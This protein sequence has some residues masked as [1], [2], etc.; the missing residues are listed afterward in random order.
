MEGVN[1]EVLGV[2]VA[3]IVACVAVWNTLRGIARDNRDAH[4]RIEKN[5]NAAKNEL[6][7]DFNKKVD[8]LRGY[9]NERFNDLNNRFD[10]WKKK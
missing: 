5:I 10:D 2:G 3:F 7:Q 4:G 9:V 8:E 1:W 6:K